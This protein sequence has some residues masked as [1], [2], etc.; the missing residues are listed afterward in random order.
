VKRKTELKTGACRAAPRNT[1][2][3]RGRRRLVARLKIAASRQVCGISSKKGKAATMY[4]AR[5]ENGNHVAAEAFAVTLN[6][7]LFI[8]SWTRARM[9]GNDTVRPREAVR[10]GKRPMTDRARVERR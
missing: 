8:K 10:I 4:H 6:R 2:V 5:P 3:H 1:P 7:D 9:Q